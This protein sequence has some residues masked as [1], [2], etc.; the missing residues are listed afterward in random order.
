MRLA[1]TAFLLSFAFMNSGE[2]SGQVVVDQSFDPAGASVIFVGDTPLAQT[3][4]ASEC[5]LL[6]EVSLDIGFSFFNPGSDVIVDIFAV[7]ANGV[8]TTSLGSVP[9]LN[10]DIPD[11]SAGGADF[12]STFG[13]GTGLAPVD[14]SSLGIM[15]NPGDQLAIVLEDPLGEIA[16][17]IFWSV[18][19]SG[20]LAGG[21]NFVQDPAGQFVDVPTGIGDLGFQT[22]VDTSVKP[23]EP[24]DDPSCFELL[25]DVKSEIEDLLAVANA[26]DAKKL[27]TA[28]GCVCWMQ[29]DVFWEQPS[30]NRLSNYGGSLFLGAAYTVKFL[31]KV[32]DPQADVI[33]DQLLDVLECIVDSEIEY[34]IANG[35]RDSFIDRAEDFAEL[36]DIIEEDLDNEFIAT[37][38]Y[39]LAWLNAFYATY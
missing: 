33:I 4:T 9:V 10:S 24:V 8:P 34:A 30:F 12:G 36:G 25:G 7:D 39:R 22:L 15:V 13:I 18:D 21:R 37:L 2:C 16:T 5:G 20:G 19:S 31:E 29:D 14:V 38:A 1:F 11:F 35:G 27:E 23:V 32:E 28:L 6:T 26:H 3:F 17:S